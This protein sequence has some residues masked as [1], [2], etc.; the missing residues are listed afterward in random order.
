MNTSP[1][2]Q[3]TA[4]SGGLCPAGYIC[5][6][7]TKYPHHHP[8]PAGTWSSTVGAHNLSSC[9]PCPPRHHCNSTGLSQPAGLCDA[10]MRISKVITEKNFV[11]LKIISIG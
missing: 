8:C 10:G 9:W 5:P 11:V 7:G 3:V 6:W 4:P 1:S 2:P